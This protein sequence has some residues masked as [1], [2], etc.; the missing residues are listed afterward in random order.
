MLTYI[1]IVCNGDAELVKQQHTPLTWYEEWF[2][3]FEYKWV[4]MLT[5]WMDA[6]AKGSFGIQCKY[7]IEV[8]KKNLELERRARDSWP[9]FAS[10]HELII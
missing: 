9:K 1:F 2:F 3:H 8:C 6:A 10:F 7:L 4:R 5:R